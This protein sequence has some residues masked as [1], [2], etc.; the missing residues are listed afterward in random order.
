MRLR[1]WEPREKKRT[2]WFAGT[3]ALAWVLGLAIPTLVGF[4]IVLVVSPESRLIFFPPVP[5]PPG[6]P[7]SAFD[8]TNRQGDQTLLGGTDS[9]LTHKSVS[10]QKEE[11][12]WEFRNLAETFAV[13]L[14]VSSGKSR[15][16]GNADLGEK[17]AASSDDDDSDATS[18]TSIDSDDDFLD[19]KDNA[20]DPD[21]TAGAGGMIITSDMYAPGEHPTELIRQNKRS[22][23]IYSKGDEDGSAGMSGQT[24]TV[25]D[26][27]TGKKKGEKA[28]SDKQRKKREA[29][30]AKIKRD[31]MVGKYLKMLQDGLGDAAD[32]SEI[33]I[34]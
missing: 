31:E 30:E 4:L 23:G 11:A 14:A 29:K 28:L 7:P 34:K 32:M 21:A 2:A 27:K 9:A 8:P 20:E 33:M 1:S 19:A 5:P 13:K 25:R 3:Y 18:V 6:Q 15:A 26:P 16:Q 24:R 17:N 10:E 12:A 22:R